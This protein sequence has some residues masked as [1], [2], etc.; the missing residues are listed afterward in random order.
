MKNIVSYYKFGEYGWGNLLSGFGSE[1]M[2]RMVT[3]TSLFP[4]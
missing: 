3:L 2:D 1:G 4:D